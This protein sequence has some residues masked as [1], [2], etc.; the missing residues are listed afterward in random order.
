MENGMK[1]YR[2]SHTKEAVPSYAAGV[3]AL[4]GVLIEVAHI[5]VLCDVH[6]WSWASYGGC[7]KC[8]DEQS[9]Q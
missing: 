9:K 3:V 8:T 7:L 6:G 4:K 1:A 5:E 2:L